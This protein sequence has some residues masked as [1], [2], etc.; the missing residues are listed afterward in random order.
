MHPSR[1][2][3]VIRALRPGA[4]SVVALLDG[5]GVELTHVTHGVWE[6]VVEGKVRDYR[7][8]VGYHGA[9]YPADDPYRYLPSLGEIDLHLIGEGRHEQLWEVLGAHVRTYDAVTGRVTGTSFAVWAPG[10]RGVRV[11]GDFNFWD[12]RAHPM[13]VLG[14][15]GVW[16]LFIP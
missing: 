11:A 13:R 2:A 14:S 4:E 16:E 8:E 6:A 10:A 5:E 1:R 15:S 3:S 7:L 9:T 12:S